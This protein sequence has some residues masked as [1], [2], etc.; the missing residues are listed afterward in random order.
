M[1]LYFLTRTIVSAIWLCTV[2]L[3]GCIAYWKKPEP[4]SN[5]DAIDGEEAEFSSAGSRASLD[6]TAKSGCPYI[7]GL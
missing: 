7:G 2:C 3:L 1:R 5:S 4:A 6:G